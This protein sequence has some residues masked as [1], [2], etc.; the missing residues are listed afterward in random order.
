[1]CTPPLP[2]HANVDGLLQRSWLLTL[3]FRSYTH[4]CTQ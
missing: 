4:A 1:M 3:C 2:L